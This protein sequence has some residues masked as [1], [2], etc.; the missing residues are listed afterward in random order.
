ME[1]STALLMC[2]LVTCSVW[3]VHGRSVQVRIDDEDQVESSMDVEGIPGKCWAC[4]WALNKV[5]KV[6]GPNA[7]AE[8]LTAKLNAVCNEIGL[9]KA[10]CRK[11]VKSYLGTL[12]EELTTTDDVRTIC[13]NIK[14]CKP[15]EALDVFIY[16]EDD[17]SRPEIKVFY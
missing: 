13:V 9:L 17:K 3:T 7:T 2:I 16:Q 14:A 6:V 10:V 11:L 12:V 1:T 15:K 4:K 5:K 8:S